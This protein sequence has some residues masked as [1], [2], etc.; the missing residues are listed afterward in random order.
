MAAFDVPEAFDPNSMQCLLVLI[1][2]LRAAGVRTFKH[3]CGLDLTLDTR[4]SSD[5]VETKSLSGEF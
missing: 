1:D 3:P 2:N 5:V 4:K